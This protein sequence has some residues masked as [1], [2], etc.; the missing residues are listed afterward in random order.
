[1]EP[2][3]VQDGGRDGVGNVLEVDFVG[4]IHRL[5]PDES[6]TF[7][8]AADLVLDTN[9]FMH[10]VVGRFNCRQGVWWLENLGRTARIDLCDELHGIT[11]QVVPGS[12]VSLTHR[13]FS[14]AF[15]AGPTGYRIDG[16]LGEPPEPETPEAPSGT[17]TVAFGSVPFSPEQYE[18]VVALVAS[19][20]ANAGRLEPTP[21]IARRLGWT[22][23]KFHRKLDLVCVKLDR[24]GVRG[25]KGDLGASA[26]LRRERL[27]A[28]VLGAGLVRIDDLRPPERIDG[29][30]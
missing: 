11:H 7:G 8:R 15:A 2:L 28:H 20:R 1:M 16:R 3:L 21:V 17:A 12:Q 14:V 4:E 24:A 19:S 29:L 27:V 9:P 22:T 10:R 13:V 23:K 5:G 18:L 30:G 26:D 6:L 25:L